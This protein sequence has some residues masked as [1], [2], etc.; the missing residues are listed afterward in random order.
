MLACMEKVRQT[1]LSRSKIGQDPRRPEIERALALAMPMTQVGRKFGYTVDAVKRHRDNMPTQLKAAI[2]AAT[3]KPKE[4]DLEKLR[5]DESEGILGNLA[6]QRARLLLLQD[7]CIEAGA[8]DSA[9]RISHVIHR[10]I[11]LVGRYL[12]QFAT[13]HVSTKI[14]I[15]VSED[16]LRLRQA[17]TLALRPHREAR[18]A[19]AAAL[20]NIEGE[21]AQRSLIEAGK[22]PPPAPVMIE[23]LP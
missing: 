13:H 3:L 16:Y 18:L 10:N 20:Q 8:V 5:I 2:I 6:G 15:L 7:Q 17:I 22:A 9:T 4:T 11:E 12:G 19:V 21:I 14:N 23:A 1:R